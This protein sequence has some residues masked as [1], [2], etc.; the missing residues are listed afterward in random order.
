M[1]ILAAL[2]LVCSFEWRVVKLAASQT[3]R[4]AWSRR[5]S[6][7]IG[8]TSMAIGSIVERRWHGD[9]AML[10]ELQIWLVY[11]LIGAGSSAISDSQYILLIQH[12][13]CFAMMG[14]GVAL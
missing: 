8:V 14:K 2:R 3:W 7:A 1:D 10:A 4:F 5:G 13:H 12:C 11:V 6:A 9:A